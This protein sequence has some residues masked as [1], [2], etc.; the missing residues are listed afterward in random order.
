MQMQIFVRSLSGKTL[1]FDV[2]SSDTVRSLKSKVE[3]RD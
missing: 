1:I 2:E 3:N